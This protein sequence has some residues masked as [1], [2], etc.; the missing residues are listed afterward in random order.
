[1]PHCVMLTLKAL[2]MR[3]RLNTRSLHPKASI[4]SRRPM[5]MSRPWRTAL[6]LP[7]SFP[8]AHAHYGR[9]HETLPPS[10]ATKCAGFLHYFTASGDPY[11]ACSL[12]I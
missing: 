9:S 2:P 3:R 1:M 11:L 12:R 4:G 10:T 5:S 8:I 7:F 6:P